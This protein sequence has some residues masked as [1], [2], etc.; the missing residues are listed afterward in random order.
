MAVKTA[1]EIETRFGISGRQLDEWEQDAS[2]GILHGK[3]SG[4]IV[5]GR[6]LKFGQEMRQVGFKE[7]LSKVEA[8][9][10]RAA[11][12]GMRR[13]DYLR[14]LVDADLKLAGLA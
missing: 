8:I 1:Q 14:H 12:L 7:P 5:M 6:P 2:R 4:E 13:S 10:R 9:D 11:E 3:P